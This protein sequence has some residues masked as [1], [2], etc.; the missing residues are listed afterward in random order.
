MT[1]QEKALAP[2]V[3]ADIDVLASLLPLGAT[4]FPVQVGLDPASGK[5]IKRPTVKEW[6]K[7]TVFPIATKEAIRGWYAY[8]FHPESIGAYVIDLDD[9]GDDGEAN[10]LAALGSDPVARGLVSSPAC[11]VDTPNGRHLYFDARDIP[12]S[13]RHSRNGILPGVDIRAEHSGGWLVAPGSVGYSL[14]RKEWR[15]YT[16]EGD[17]SALPRMPEELVR[18][19]SRL[20]GELEARDNPRTE[21]TPSFL[22]GAPAAPVPEIP[23]DDTDHKLAEL[24]ATASQVIRVPELFTRLV[25]HYAPSAK[26][27]QGNYV[28]G[29][30]A[31]NPGMSCVWTPSNGVIKDFADPGKGGDFLWLL[32][33]HRG[34]GNVEAARAILGTLGI[35][36][37]TRTLELVQSDAADAASPATPV[38][39]GMWPMTD[40]GNAERFV[41]M[42]Q[43]NL[44]YNT[45]QGRWFAY[46]GRSYNPDPGSATS[47]LAKSVARSMSRQ[48]STV[49]DPEVAQA[50]AKWARV[51]ESDTRR[52]AMVSCAQ[53]EPRVARPDSAF[54]TDQDCLNTLSGLV[55]L[56]TGKVTPHT[57]SSLVTQL[58]PYEVSREK[59]VRFLSF[60]DDI[61]LGKPEII[62]W[63]HL[64]LGYSLTGRMSDQ[65]FP[66]W[67]GTGQNGKSV[68]LA[69]VGGI[70]GSYCKKTAAE[71]WL[72]N[73]G[74]MPVRDDL[75]ILRGA[76]FVWASEP[77]PGKTLSIA[78][79]KEVTGGDPV[80]CRHLYGRPFTYT[81]QF[82]M[83]FVTNHRPMVKSQDFG[84]WRRLRF[85][86]FTYRVPEEKK[87]GDL[88]EILLK[89]EGSKILGW[90]IEGAMRWYALGKLPPCAEIDA[91]TAEL[92]T[93]DDPLSEFI[94]EECYM[95]TG[96][97][98]MFDQ[99]W[100][101]YTA[102]NRDKGIQNF[103]SRQVFRR[104]LMERNDIEFR[105][106]L[107]KTVL[108]G[109]GLRFKG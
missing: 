68:L 1:V 83:A 15:W 47:Q 3:G 38:L 8:G 66:I 39:T 103:L 31:G 44:V 54:D 57:P 102:W 62:E 23:K 74:N 5:C 107:M 36:D 73:R 48:A 41:E 81:P 72:Q 82:K 55:D 108:Y 95:G 64:Y 78:T 70:M 42:A 100:A 43:G 59:P 77:D 109:I 63:M 2:T 84:T 101:A 76:R 50:L 27:Y 45:D 29:D 25:K 11:Y 97:K 14:K 51:S 98:V 106:E 85:I 104:I 105:S 32:S 79:I 60:L 69:V 16:L 17:L 10:L 56:K 49:N 91:A 90:M 86:P 75:A 87:V 22:V 88:W 96:S 13:I 28:T 4:L 12:E 71:T 52:K 37:P 53:S 46:D 18:L 30:Y 19:L 94:T 7:T 6:Q 92:K 33:T 65:V 80:T 20:F 35:P 93:G 99:L 21:S 58:C 26:L 61:F 89:E 24:F 67:W 34:M 40:T 9:K